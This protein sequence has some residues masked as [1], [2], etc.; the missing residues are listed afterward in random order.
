MAWLGAQVAVKQAKLGQDHSLQATTGQH[1][2]CSIPVTWAIPMIHS[3]WVTTHRWSQFE[4]DRLDRDPLEI[5]GL[6]IP[7]QRG[8]HH[9]VDIDSG[10]LVTMGCQSVA[11]DQHT[12]LR[13]LIGGIV[14]AVAVKALGLGSFLVGNTRPVQ[15]HTALGLSDAIGSGAFGRLWCGVR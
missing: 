15:A 10:A 14:R 1:R 6:G 5:E 4:I 7:A 9:H 3:A 8:R 12:I 2:A 13:V 11:A